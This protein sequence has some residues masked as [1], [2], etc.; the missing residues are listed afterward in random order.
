M[1]SLLSVAVIDPPVKL[2]FPFPSV[3]GAKPNGWEGYIYFRTARVPLPFESAFLQAWRSYKPQ[4]I[5]RGFTVSF[6]NGA[7]VLTQN[8]AGAPGHYTLTPLGQEILDSA[9]QP[10]QLDLTFAETELTLP[11]L[12]PEIQRILRS[13]QITPTKQLLR[14]LI[15]GIKEW[16]YHG[17][18]DLSDMGAGKTAM[19]L[20]AALAFCRL[21]GRS[22][23]AALM[24][25]VGR[26]GWEYMFKLFGAEPYHL[27][28]YEALR[29][30]NRPHLVEQVGENM[31]WKNAGDMVLILDEAQ[32]VR[33][34]DTLNYRLCDGAIQQGIPIICA[35]A[36]LALSPIEL[37]FAGRVTGLHRGGHDFDRFLLAHGCARP[38]KSAPYKWNS[39]L[40]TLASIHAKLFPRRGCRVRKEQAGEYNPGT[41]I[42]VLLVE[43]PRSVELEQKWQAAEA[44]LD[45]MRRTG[46]KEGAIETVRQNLYMACWKLAEEITIPYVASHAR[47]RMQSGRSVA[48]FMSFTSTREEMC[49]QMKTRAGFYGG[50]TQKR[51]EYYQQQ[52]QTNREHI[53]IN[54][55]RAGGAS[56]SLHDI[57][58][59]RPRTAY[60]WPDINPVAVQQATGRVDR[61][62]GKTVSEQFIVCVKGPFSERMVAQLRSKIQRMMT[63]NDGGGQAHRF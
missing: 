12:P 39:D 40:R 37:R 42:S 16:A 5:R 62:G 24:P 21:S 15:E 8:L 45:N 19:D 20:A 48:M 32:A 57:T 27:G 10:A 50:M 61:T 3:L 36:T 43:S 41:S 38:S 22:K 29:A 52:F 60:I 18:A 6:E 23:I 11:D 4:F 63:L 26:T 56:V 33:H 54:Q 28:T 7:W 31:R 58:G 2:P 59:D 47:K 25:V 51:R 34:D 9:T 35:S 55:I 1:N 49:K 30:G 53:L 13:Y 17:A 46:K 44:V 14:A